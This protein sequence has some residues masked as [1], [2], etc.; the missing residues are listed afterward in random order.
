VIS[1]NDRKDLP[2][3]TIPSNTTSDRMNIHLTRYLPGGKREEVYRATCS[4]SEL[5]IVL[6][7]LGKEFAEVYKRRLGTQL[8]R[9]GPAWLER[10]GYAVILP[11]AVWKW[12]SATIPKRKGRYRVDPNIFEN[13]PIPAGSLSATPNV[14]RGL[15]ASGYRGSVCAVRTA[16]PARGRIIVLSYSPPGQK[17]AGWYIVSSDR[18]AA[19]INAVIE[20]I[21][22]KVVLTMPDVITR[23][24]QEMR[25]D[26]IGF[27]L[28]WLEAPRQ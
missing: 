18:Q 23:I 15:M 17:R 11:E 14:L 25:L 28:D 10:R 27:A 22:R 20:S 13:L 6:E 1:R 16:R 5:G 19:E 7:G 8:R 26:E 2:H 24:F 4:K 9:V 3:L 21:V 12:L